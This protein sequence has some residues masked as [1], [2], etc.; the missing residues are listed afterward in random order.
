[1]S[2]RDQGMAVES[3]GEDLFADRLGLL[4][5]LVGKAIG[6]PGLT[7]AFDQERAHLG[8]IA[9]VVR[10]EAA[11]VG[12]DKSLRQGLETPGRAVPGELVAGVGQRAAEIALETAA[13]QRVE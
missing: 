12:L 6:L 4:D 3:G 7:I 9:I 11:E 2:V 13:Y 1:R 5:A 10:V 8:R